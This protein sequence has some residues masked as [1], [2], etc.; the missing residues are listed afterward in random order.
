MGFWLFRVSRYILMEQQVGGV[1]RSSRTRLFNMLLGN[2]LTREDVVRPLCR[3]PWSETV[4]AALTRLFLPPN[5][6]NPSGLQR[7]QFPHQWSPVQFPQRCLE[8][9]SFLSLGD[10]AEHSPPHL[11]K[12]AVFSSGN[13]RR[14]GSG[15]DSCR[16]LCSALFFLWKGVSTK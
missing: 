13:K 9:G 7:A 10:V 15:F 12:S 5:R 6:I 11:Q 16:P 14:G 4:V 8:V 2:K 3:T 1:T